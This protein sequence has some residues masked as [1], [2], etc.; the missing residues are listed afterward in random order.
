MKKRIGRRRAVASLGLGGLALA[1]AG[2][3]DPAAVLSGDTAAPLASWLRSMI[4]DLD[5][6]RRIGR[7]YLETAP[8]ASRERLLVELFPRLEP[9]MGDWRDSFAARCRQDFA[10]GNTLRIEGW[11]LAR[12]EVRLCALAALA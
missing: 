2:R 1:L 8:E 5:S 9:A 11:V 4:G 3:V 10:D 12:T 6:A 7:A